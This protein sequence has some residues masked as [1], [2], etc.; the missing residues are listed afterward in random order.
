MDE[1]GEVFVSR[2]LFPINAPLSYDT[3]ELLDVGDG[4]GTVDPD[5][6][7]VLCAIPEM[8]G[9]CVTAIPR[10]GTITWPASGT[11]RCRD[12]ELTL[13]TARQV[14]RFQPSGLY[15]SVECGAE[16]LALNR[17]DHIPYNGRFT[18]SATD[19]E[20]NRLSVVITLSGSVYV[21]HF[22]AQYGCPC[23]PTT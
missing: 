12:G 18:V 8:A 3:G 4:Y 13:T 1:T 23:R 9:S 16:E 17:G 15:G 21:G 14:F 7:L 6:Y 19:T 2:N 20:G 22:T 11:L 10:L 5:D